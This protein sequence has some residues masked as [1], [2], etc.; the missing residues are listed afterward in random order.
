MRD[1]NVLLPKSVCMCY[2]KKLGP[3]PPPPH[4][5]IGRKSVQ[6]DLKQNIMDA[7]TKK[8][9]KDVKQNV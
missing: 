2:Q 1:Q 3:P 6:M 7:K 5:T 9:T 4:R 8:G